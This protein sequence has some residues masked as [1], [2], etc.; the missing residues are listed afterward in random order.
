MR[1]ADVKGI[2]AGWPLILSMKFRKHSSGVDKLLRLPV[3]GVLEC[4]SVH[5]AR[6]GYT[7]RHGCQETP[8][9]FGERLS[10]KNDASNATSK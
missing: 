5:K 8:I 3:L 6:R 2:F 10:T 1:M 7:T 4:G 9:V